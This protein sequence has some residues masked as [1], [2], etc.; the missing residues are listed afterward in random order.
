MRTNPLPAAPGSPGDG[1]RAIAF[2]PE[3]PGLAE[4]A[5]DVL[6][7]L[8]LVLGLAAAMLWLA[9]RQG[10]LARWTG[11]PGEMFPTGM[12]VEQRLRLS[13][14][15]TVYRIS[16]GTLRYVVVESSAD[17]HLHLLPQSRSQ[18]RSE[19]EHG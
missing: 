9:R 5:T 15:T 6:V 12:R 14:R 2:R 16:D 3:G 13:P 1:L 4:G 17:T 19:N 8:V 11:R 7:A 10:W 18:A